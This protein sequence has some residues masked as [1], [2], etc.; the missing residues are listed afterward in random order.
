MLIWSDIV[1]PSITYDDIVMM[2]LCFLYIDGRCPDGM[3]SGGTSHVI[4]YQG[5]NCAG[6][7]SGV[8]PVPFPIVSYS[9]PSSFQTPMS[10]SQGTVDYWTNGKCGKRGNVLLCILPHY[11][12]LCCYGV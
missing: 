4:C 10:H 2:S 3:S 12:A 5:Q 7:V 9:I 6:L 1:R 8:N 11:L